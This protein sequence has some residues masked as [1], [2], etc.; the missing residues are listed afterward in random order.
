MTFVLVM[1]PVSEFLVGE[2]G[3]STEDGGARAAQHLQ[4]AQPSAWSR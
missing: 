3:E 2:A 1:W 4:K